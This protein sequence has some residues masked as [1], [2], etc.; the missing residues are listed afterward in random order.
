MI[1][2]IKSYD[3]AYLEIEL[4]AHQA[5]RKIEDRW[6]KDTAEMFHLQI[7][8]RTGTI[9]I[10]DKEGVVCVKVGVL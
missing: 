1:N 4:M 5:L 3:L 10:R 2:S 6:N 7:D 9:T 8:K